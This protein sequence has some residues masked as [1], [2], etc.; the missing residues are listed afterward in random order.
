MWRRRKEGSDVRKW[1]LGSPGDGSGL[2]CGCTLL[3][4]NKIESKVLLLEF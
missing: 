2:V 1:S 3:C 4:F